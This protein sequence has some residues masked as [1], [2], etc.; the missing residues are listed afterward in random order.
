MAQT[1]VEVDESGAQGGTKSVRSLGRALDILSCFDVEHPCW[2]IP[3]LS[4]RTGL[5][6]ATVHR[7]V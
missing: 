3:G 2:D 4:Q 5:H 6:K 7:L 1:L